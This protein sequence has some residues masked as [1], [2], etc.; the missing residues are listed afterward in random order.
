[1]GWGVWISH[2]GINA[3]NCVISRDAVI[4]SPNFGHFPPGNC[5]YHNDA[6]DA[7]QHLFNIAKS[8]TEFSFLGWKPK[9]VSCFGKPKSLLAR[10]RDVSWLE[11]D[12]DW[13]STANVCPKGRNDGS[14]RLKTCVRKVERLCSFYYSVSD[15]LLALAISGMSCFESY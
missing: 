14:S 8:I 2:V 5:L 13:T 10:R 6:I 11:F 9:P 7:P 3:S 1:M 12:N 4:N 15:A